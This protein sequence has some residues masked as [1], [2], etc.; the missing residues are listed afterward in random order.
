MLMIAVGAAGQLTVHPDNPRYF[1]DPASGKALLLAGSH[2]WPTLVDMGDGDTPPA[3]DFDKYLAFMSEHRHNFLRLWTWEPSLWGEHVNKTRPQQRRSSAPLP[4]ARTGPGNAADGKAKFDLTR[5]DDD[6]FKRLR[7]RVEAARKA[8][9]YVS[10]MLFEG[11]GVQFYKD[12]WKHHPYHAANNIQGIEADRDG[13][14][15]GM[16]VHEL[17]NEKVTALQE[18]YVRKVIDTVNDLDN[19]LYEISNENHP[20]STQ[21]QYHMIRFIKQYEKGKPKQHPVGMTFQFKGGSNKTL[22]ESPA[23]WV[24]PNPEAGGGFEYKKNPPVAEGKKVVISDTDHLWG[25]GGDVAWVWKTFLRGH[26]P[27]FMD[28]YGRETFGKTRLDCDPI[29]KNLGYVLDYS[30]RVDLA[31]MSP[32]L[33]IASSGYC[34]ASAGE[35]RPAYLVFL[36]EGGKVNVDLTGT[37]AKLAVEW[38]DPASGKATAGDAVMG[39][40]SAELTAPFPGPAVLF[41]QA[42]GQK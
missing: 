34:L 35:S 31:V 21:W 17:G 7:A 38:F 30:R 24:S 18:A 22:F 14:G 42:S 23:D 6:Y 1:K 16:E 33:K 5:Y 3:F 19:V 27:I 4:Y 2:T 13:D 10:V 36:P 28:P 15:M 9:I 11:Y 20:Q 25:L 39:G 29:R 40:A 8:G 32:H 41:I 26:N 12:A 37:K